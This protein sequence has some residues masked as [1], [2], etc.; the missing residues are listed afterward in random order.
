[1]C[2]KCTSAINK[3]DLRRL[4]S[5]LS[6]LL[7]EADEHNARCG[8]PDRLCVFCWTR[9]YDAIEGLVHSDGCVIRQARKTLRAV[10]ARQVAY[11]D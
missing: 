5:A 7:A 11:K 8:K 10:G 3:L 2:E 1:M 9:H 6:R 4:V